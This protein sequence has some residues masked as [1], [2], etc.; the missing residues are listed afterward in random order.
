MHVAQNAQGFEIA[1]CTE[2]HF[3][4]RMNI[5]PRRALSQWQ[6]LSSSKSPAITC[7]TQ[8]RRQGGGPLLERRSSAKA[9]ASA[10]SAMI[11]VRCPPKVLHPVSRAYRS[12][13]FPDKRVDVANS[14]YHISTLSSF[15]PFNLGST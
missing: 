14:V 10:A 1:T 15:D 12:L 9:V 7:R 4:R 3:A 13:F 5:L 2:Q 6:R 11:W 8:S